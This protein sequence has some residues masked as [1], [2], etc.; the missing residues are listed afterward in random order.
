[1]IS[2]LS[3]YYDQ[4]KD[5]V[6]EPLEVGEKV[7]SYY[8]RR[9]P[10]KRMMSTLI[11]FTPEGIILTGDLRPAQRG[12]MTMEYGLT[13]FCSELEPRYLAGKFLEKKW[14][15]AKAMEWL[16][17][18]I[19][20]LRAIPDDAIPEDDPALNG[21]GESEPGEGKPGKNEPNPYHADT[22]RLSKLLEDLSNFDSP[23]EF[24][25]ALVNTKP[26]T[27]VYDYDTVSC[28][29]DYDDNE[30]GWLYAIQRRFAELMRPQLNSLEE[31]VNQ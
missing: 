28:G 21:S 19:K 22:D 15:P 8:L 10:G 9:F 17:S 12:C 27:Q 13:W 7:R 1:M 26:E 16:E 5:A 30:V 11:V 4:L 2:D 31:G 24:Y 14:Q 29:E 6:V 25:W 3:W 23:Q 20:D 18:H